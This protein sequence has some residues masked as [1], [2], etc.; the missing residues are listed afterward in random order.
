MTPAK[1]KS[2]F[3]TFAEIGR[4]CRVSREAVRRWKRIPAEHCRALAEASGGAI[5]ES[6]MRPDVFGKP[7]RQPRRRPAP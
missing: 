7:T 1:L 3:R 2:H 6:D 5:S 4:V